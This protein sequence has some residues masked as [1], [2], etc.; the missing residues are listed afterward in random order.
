MSYCHSQGFVHRD[1][2]TENI[3]LDSDCNV[4]IA[5]F[6]LSCRF[7]FNAYLSESC[8][9]PNY[10]A[11][12]LFNIPCYYRGPEIDAW[13]SGVVF[14][15]M[16]C[17]RLPFDAQN[18]VDVRENIRRGTYK[19]Y[20]Y[21]SKEAEDFLTQVLTKDPKKRLRIMK[22]QEHPWFMG[23]SAP[24]PT[25]DNAPCTQSSIGKAIEAGGA[26]FVDGD[27]ETA[28]VAAKAPWRAFDAISR[29][30]RSGKRRITGCANAAAGGGSCAC[31][32]KS[33]TPHSRWWHLP[34]GSVVP[35]RVRKFLATCT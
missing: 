21:F 14:Y 33:A 3:L 19:M 18:I 31:P 8:G 30:R 25:T 12:E 2:K 17:G 6:G 4:K 11:P 28:I 24:C 23:E 13:S 15:A 20:P 29:R 5:D 26:Q 7:S 1:L 16:L 32:P 10:A 27:I 9:S 22:M 34:P 35:A